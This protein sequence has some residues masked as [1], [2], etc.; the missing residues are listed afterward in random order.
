MSLGD[1]FQAQGAYSRLEFLRQDIKGIQAALGD[2]KLDV[3]V[4]SRV[5][6]DV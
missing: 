1:R 6:S 3:F 5:P 4:V 2:T